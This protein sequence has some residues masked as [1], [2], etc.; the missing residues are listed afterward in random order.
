[1]RETIYNLF[2]VIEHDG[3]V[4]S[5][6]VVGHECGGGDEGKYRLLQGAVEEDIPAARIFPVPKRFVTFVEGGRELESVEG[7]ISFAHYETLLRDGA[8]LDLFEELLE[9]VDAPP[10]PL[11]CITPVVD[12]VPVIDGVTRFGAGPLT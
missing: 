6:G 1:V 3:L 2:L 4:R 9:V 7:S 5:L 11:V 8:H 10:D 12:G